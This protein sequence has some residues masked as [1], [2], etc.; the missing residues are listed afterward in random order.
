MCAFMVFGR[1][2]EMY[3]LIIANPMNML[4]KGRNE[5]VNDFVNR[6]YVATSAQI[7]YLGLCKP[8]LH[9][10]RSVLPYPRQWMRY[11]KDWW[12]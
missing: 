6:A 5:N 12:R 4:A 11:S 7:K 8:C 3:S 9:G 2:A 10:S 1:S